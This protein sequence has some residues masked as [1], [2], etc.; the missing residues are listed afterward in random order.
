[1][2]A[3]DPSRVPQIWPDQ[4]YDLV[5]VFTSSGQGGGMEF[6]EVPQMLLAGDQPTPIGMTGPE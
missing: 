2:L 5:W 1:M 6:R 3:E 4:R